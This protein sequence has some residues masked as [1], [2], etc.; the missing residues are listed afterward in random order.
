[1]TKKDFIEQI[2]IDL[3]EYDEVPSPRTTNFHF[4]E[5]SGSTQDCHFCSDRSSDRKRTKYRCKAC[6]EP[7]CIDPCFADIHMM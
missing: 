4:P 2:V 1:M 5:R 7:L 3:T 6:M